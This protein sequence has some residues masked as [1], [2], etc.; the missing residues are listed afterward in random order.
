MFRRFWFFITRWRRIQDLDEEMRLHV[1]LRAAANRRDGLHAEEA[2]RQARLRFG[3]PL[4]LREDAR[5][6]YGFAEL[7][8]V[9]G[10]LRHAVRRI[11][12]QPARTLVVVLTLALGI[13]ATT[14]MF[15]LVDALLLK[16]AP[17]DKSGRAVWIAG[18]EGHS[19][20]PRNVSYP[21]Y[22]VY[23]A[24]T[25][26]LSGVAAEGGT[27]MSFG[28]RQPQRVLGGLVSGNYFDVL[29]IR[30][31]V[32]RT[33]APDEDTGRNA[34][35]VV[36]L[37]AAL[38]TEQ[39]GAD[40]GV[41]GTRLAINGKSFTIIGVAPRGFTGA[42]FA[43]NPY[44]LWIPM[45]MQGAVMPRDTAFLTDANEAWLLVV[46]RLRDGVAL[47]EADAEVRVIASQVNSPQ[48]PDDQRKSA[49]VLPMR[50]GLTPGEQK[51][52]ALVFGL[53]SIVPAL[54]LLVACA[55]TA[56]VLMAH[57]SARRREF[58][59]RRAIGA[60]RGRLVRQLVAESVVVAL[61]A[62]PAGFGASFVLST[63][64]AQVGEVPSDVSALLAHGG[65]TLL[66]A[67]AIAVGA[68]L[69]FGL[70]PA[71]T[72]TRFDVLAVLKDEGTTSTAARGPAR[73][74]RSFLVAQVALS[75]TLLV[76]AGLF[77]QSLSRALRVEPGFD[78]QGLAIVSFD[79]NRQGYAADRRGA[80]A[81]RFVER[82]TVLP[83]VASVATADV[84]PL[85]GEMYGRTIVSEDGAS[86]SQA[87]MASVS[88]RYFE[89]LGLPVV[90]GREFSPA[91]IAANAPVAIIN[92]T[93][94]RSLWPGVDPLGKH[95]RAAES[96]EPWR[97]IVGIARDAKYLSLTESAL[98]A[99]Y[100][101]E[102]P[103][104]VGTLVVRTV[105]SPQT[106][107]ASLRSIARDLD[108]DLPLF[109]AQTMEERI[110]RTVQLRRAVVSLLGVLGALTLLLASIGIYGVA[111]HSVSMRTREVGIRMSLGARA[112]DV[113]WM[114]VGEN[115]SLSFVGVAIG[116]GLSA[117][118]LMMLAS[119]LFGVTSGDAATFVGGALVLFLV[120][121]VAS[122]LPARRAARLDPVLALRRE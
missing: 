4:M 1:E 100:V 97:A 98:G 21:D 19:A 112:A 18:L 5:D 25:T 20:E 121:L 118:G 113:Q 13:R 111:S 2:T 101:P 59:M 9:A 45:A 28:G 6:A 54:V 8:R 102:S 65:R 80:F 43:T 122:Y 56:N 33:F 32:G 62:G 74:R 15:T 108:P 49:R 67:T 87:S 92:E 90:R 70:A 116:L 40:P 73:L 93:L 42:A 110:R 95:V 99:Y 71:L 88:S 55:N 89:T 39:F 58:A 86:S 77:F 109:S 117:A 50:G 10:D 24:R 31:Q 3:N 11:V 83:N 12:Q 35:P 27:A 76:T 114:I 82:V 64:I 34:H 37:S 41:I 91:E 119:Y 38:W 23:R 57:Y 22:L 107:L 96:E 51:S 94:A 7:E 84:L 16:P 66:A 115:L 68:V 69:I 79:L 105:G 78:P 44:Q 47:A 63:V 26:T 103:Q 61:L 29:G 17:W 106:V 81:A 120:S 75:L 14:A 85:G 30:A 60:S 48:T 53:V 52:L 72:T 104:S 36:V 46:G